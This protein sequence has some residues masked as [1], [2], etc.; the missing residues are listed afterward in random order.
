MN[1]VKKGLAFMLLMVITIGCFALEPPKMQ[2]LKLM[3]N[4]QRM[5]MAWSNSSDC[6]RF[7]TFYFY[8]NG[9]LCDS[10][11]CSSGY[12]FCNYGSKDIN[13]VPVGNEYSC[14]IMAVD[15]NNN[16]YYSD[17]I[18]S[19]SLTVTPIANNTMALL[20]WEA[21][22][23]NL[24]A[25]WDPNFQ[26]YKM[27]AFESDFSYTP[28]ATIPNTRRSYTD[29]SDVCDN[30]IYYQVNIYNHYTNTDR[31]EF[32]TTIGSARLVD[33]ISPT[34]PI[35]D[36][37]TVTPTNEVMLGFHGSEPYMMAYI[38]YYIN[39]NGTIPFDTVYG[40]ESEQ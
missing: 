21:P 33:S 10:L 31:C 4:N 38:I 18:H 14:Y 11:T 32:R 3:N 16:A 36:S 1:R 34:P 2:C 23:T 27:R 22:S 26:I 7:K 9:V 17:T 8:I 15:S 37:V 25:S 5:N 20:E 24:D 35:L 28:I 29:T 39:A 6:S 13:F 12:T 19:I 30:T 40:H